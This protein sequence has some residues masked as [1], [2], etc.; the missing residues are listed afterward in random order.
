MI[1]RWDYLIIL[2]LFFGLGMQNCCPSRNSSPPEQD[3]SKTVA[4]PPVLPPAPVNLPPGVARIVALP[5]SLDRQESASF[6]ILR[7]EKVVGYGMSTP[8][9][10]VGSEIR[11]EMGIEQ[12]QQQMAQFNSALQQKS[13]LTLTL[14]TSTE[15]A[16]EVKGSGWKVVG[17]D[18][19]STTNSPEE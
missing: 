8:L 10:T 17:I 4:P 19:M 7:V 9:V 14:R 12:D 16:A 6:C 11:V 2:L 1:I 5:V 18:K 3:A 15:K 13:P